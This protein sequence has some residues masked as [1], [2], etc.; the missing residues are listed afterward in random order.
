MPGLDGCVGG[1]KRRVKMEGVLNVPTR[2]SWWVAMVWV[3]VISLVLLS[4]YYG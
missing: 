3:V 1:V 4:V 2:R